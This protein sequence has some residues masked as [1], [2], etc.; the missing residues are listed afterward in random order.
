MDVSSINAGVLLTVGSIVFSAGAFYAVSRRD[1]QAIRSDLIRT[2]A[3][4]KE[5]IA[6][7]KFDLKALNKVVM[8]VALQNQRLD[9]QGERLNVI[10]K[11]FEARWD[12]LRRGEGV[13]T[14]GGKGA[15]TGRFWGIWVG[16][17]ICGFS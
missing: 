11:R 1:A 6:D 14:G 10:E 16:W 5:D 2:N 7:I 9:N 3:E 8:D 15:R 12:E 17:V 4:M 13:V